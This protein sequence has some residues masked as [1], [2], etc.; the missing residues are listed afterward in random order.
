M[1]ALAPPLVLVHG[2]GMDPSTWAP[3]IPALRERGDVRCP[4]LPGHA[5]TPMRVEGETALER[6][7][8]SLDAAADWVGWSL[9]GLLVLQLA[10][11]RPER[12]RRLVLVAS[13]PRFVAGDGWDAG[14]DPDLLAGFAARLEQEPEATRQRFLAL[15]VRG[16]ATARAL[17][18]RLRDHA[19]QAP[20]NSLEG[21]RWGLRQLR[22][23]DL[24][25]ALA[26]RAGPCGFILG[27]R[28]PLVS[29]G[30]PAA[31]GRLNPA[32]GVR[33]MSGA[34]HMP[35]WSDSARFVQLLRGFLD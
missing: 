11:L 28:D 8:D 1:T 34:A 27:D 13:G 33:V 9:G 4:A 15:M 2:W 3:V 35:H 24:R 14:V 16:D 21:L 29:T 7:A 32:A 12:V 18:R 31:L 5:G 10:A 23:L 19:R 6:V 30:L 17:L 26:R 20:P 22:E 25:A